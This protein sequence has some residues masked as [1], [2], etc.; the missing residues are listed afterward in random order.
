MARLKHSELYNEKFVSNAGVD[1]AFKEFLA[2][3]E[4]ELEVIQEEYHCLINCYLR[5]IPTTENVSGGKIKLW[6]VKIK[7]I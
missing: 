2:S 1:F 7:R 6:G 4:K 5:E 3:G